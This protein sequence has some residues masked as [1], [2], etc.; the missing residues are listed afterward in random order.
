MP[1]RIHA[2]DL[3]ALLN[4]DRQVYLNHFGDPAQKAPPSAY[5]SWL[6]EQGR[7][8]ENTVIEGFDFQKPPYTIENLEMGADITLQLMKEGVGLIYQ[9]VL[10]D[11][12]RVGIPDL[13]ERVDGPSKLGAFHYRPIDIKSASNESE[14]HRLQV[15]HYLSL[16]ALVQ[17]ITPV[18]ELWLRQSPEDRGEHEQPN[19]VPVEFDEAR[20][21]ERLAEVRELA[22]GREP[23]PFLSS[24]CGDCQWRGV[25]VPMVEAAQ[26]VSLIPGLRR[27]VWRTLHERGVST[28]AAMA[29][30]EPADILNIKGVGEKTAPGL[31]LKARALSEGRV[32]PLAKPALPEGEVIIFDIESV[33]SEAIYY[34]MGT[35]VDDGSGFAYR[36]EVAERLEDEPKLWQDFVQRI[37]A[38]PGA[39]VHYGKYEQTTIRKLADRH[40]LAAEAN[41]LMA[42]MVDLEKVLKDSVVLPLRSASLKAV[43]PWLGFEWTGEVEGA[44]DSVLEYLHWLEDGDRV[45]LD[46]ILT[47]NEDDC[48]ATLKVLEWLRTLA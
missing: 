19:R 36:C 33:P 42:R 6:I 17:G 13:L 10:I 40:G 27:D 22:G 38:L 43:A 30:N 1:R 16:L 46:R 14:G 20:Y 45:H 9:G 23:R 18:G 28:L 21:M 35:L 12:D 31:I 34:L 37:S 47:Y 48:R 39:I 25:C 44:D 41:A 15:M 29:A 24:V 2:G 32:I 5:R 7:Q 8:H 4:C 11:A 3:Q 26:D